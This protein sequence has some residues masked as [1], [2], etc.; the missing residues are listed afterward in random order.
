MLLPSTPS[1]VRCEQTSAIQIPRSLSRADRVVHA[2][3]ARSACAADPG[4]TTGIMVYAARTSS[5]VDGPWFS[6]R[7]RFCLCY[8]NSAA[9]GPPHRLDAGIPS[10][11]LARGPHY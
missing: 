7:G 9:V 6:F 5:W 8:S 1:W 3:G 10:E 2:R 4:A 11:D